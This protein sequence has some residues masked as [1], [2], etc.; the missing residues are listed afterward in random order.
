MSRA[1]PGQTPRSHKHTCVQ[2]ESLLLLLVPSTWSLE[3]PGSLRSSTGHTHCHTQLLLAGQH[4]LDSFSDFL[5]SQGH[6]HLGYRG[7]LLR[8][9]TTR[10]PYSLRLPK[11]GGSASACRSAPGS[12]QPAACSPGA[13]CT[14]HWSLIT[15]DEDGRCRE[16]PVR[17]CSLYTP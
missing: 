15:L 12:A 9:E 3:G 5:W 6:H 10:S 4:V 14:L 17:M 13:D 2:P 8:T 7:S 1:S 16:L 11:E